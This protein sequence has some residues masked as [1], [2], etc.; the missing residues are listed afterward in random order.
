MINHDMNDQ[1]QDEYIPAYPNQQ[2]QGQQYPPAVRYSSD[3]YQ[4][5]SNL[6]EIQPRPSIMTVRQSNKLQELREKC[7]E[8]LA[9]QRKA[10]IHERRHS[11]MPQS[12][13]S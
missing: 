13:S 2:Y 1:N 10:M 12:K 8:R 11:Q 3:N 7:F 9:L 5:F 6:D 4:N